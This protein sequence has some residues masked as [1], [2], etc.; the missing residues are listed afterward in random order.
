MRIWIG[1]QAVFFFAAKRCRI[2]RAVLKSLIFMNS[3]PPLV[4]SQECSLRINSSHC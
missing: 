4:L 1:P 3:K 2:T